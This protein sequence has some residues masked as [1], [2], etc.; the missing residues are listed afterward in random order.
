MKILILKPSSLGDVVQ[1]LPVARLLRRQIAGARIHWW[2]NRD[3]LPLLDGDPDIEKIVPFD[4]KLW[5]SPLG[6]PDAFSTVRTLR[7]ERYDWVIDLQ[8]LARSAL[9]GWVARGA[10][11]VGLDDPR[12]G[13]PALYDLA[14]PRRTFSTHAVEWYLDVVRA[15][16]VPVDLDFEWMPRRASVEARLKRHWFA[17]EMFSQQRPACR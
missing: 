3:L 5:G 15:L 4:R 14:V 9:L 16:G 6:L 13:A 8:S 11:T 2:L 12:E 17:P 1:A 7:S 10:W